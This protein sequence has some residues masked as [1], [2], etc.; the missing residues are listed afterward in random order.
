MSF[1][2]LIMVSLAELVEY[3][4]IGCVSL[5]L[6]PVTFGQA[7]WTAMRQAGPNHWCP[8]DSP[9]FDDCLLS[10]AS[11]AVFLWLFVAMGI[12]FAVN[13]Y[14]SPVPRQEEKKPI[15]AAT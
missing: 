7:L 14:R 15:I 3:I 6:L 13:A 11:F 5:F 9:T 8:P 1:V 2:L 4:C 12:M 10:V